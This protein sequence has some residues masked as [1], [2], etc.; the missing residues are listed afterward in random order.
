[1]LSYASL[2]LDS[3]K[4]AGKS[5][6]SVMKIAQVT[7][8]YEAVP[9]L[10]YG[11]TERVIA[12]LTEALVS[13]GHDVTLFASADSQTR[14][15]LVSVRD[16]AMRLDP[17]PLRSD[18]A[19]HLTLLSEVRRRAHEFDI[20]HFHTD[21]IHFPLFED[22]AEKTI[23]TLHGRLDLLDLPNVYRRWRRFPLVSISDSQRRFLPFAN[24]VGTVHHG[25]PKEFYRLSDRGEG[26]LAFLGRISPEK[27]P[28]RAI[29]IAERVGRPLKIAAKIDPVDRPY[30]HETI[31]PMIEGEPLIDYIGE[32]DDGQKADFLGAA[33][34]LLFPIDWP[35]PFGLVVIE[36]MSCGTPVIA[37]NCGSVPEIVE[38]GVTGFIVSNQ[39]EAVAAVNRLDQLDRAQIRKRFELRYSSSVMARRYLDLYSRLP[40]S[41]SATDMQTVAR[42]NGH[43]QSAPPGLA[44]DA[45]MPSVK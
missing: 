5:A 33:D 6:Q 19:A 17:T 26:Y 32:I 44:K 25:I 20:I 37:Y 39:D 38:H 7:P 10:L 28:D 8:L 29:E 43:A 27:R 31:E 35:E 4:C 13:L 1:M 36:A 40:A 23:T 16:R 14:A 9:P 21:M 41:Q 30:F 45:V 34:A 12:H 3:R 24:W 11:G 15:K 18:L 2:G 42:S 22:I